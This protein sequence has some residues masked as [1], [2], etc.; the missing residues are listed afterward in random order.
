MT[1]T[2]AYR[3][4]VTVNSND[5]FTNVS[6][7]ANDIR[8]WDNRTNIVRNNVSWAKVNST[9]VARTNAFMNKCFQNIFLNQ[10]LLEQM[11]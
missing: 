5:H 7:R 10:I 2:Q 3:I 6:N 4:I 11:S 8:I 1:N 9:N